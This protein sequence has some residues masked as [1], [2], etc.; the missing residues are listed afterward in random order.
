MSSHQRNHK[1]RKLEKN[2]LI[3]AQSR[4]EFIIIMSQK[5]Q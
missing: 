5:F 3:N 1:R 4:V 2:E